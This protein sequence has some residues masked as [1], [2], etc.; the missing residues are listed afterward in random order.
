MPM[1]PSKKKKT[2]TDYQSELHAIS[3]LPL[4]VLDERLQKMRGK[5]VTVQ[6]Q[7]I[8]PDR[9]AFEIQHR[10]DRRINAQVYGTLQRWQGTYSRLDADSQVHVFGQW[11]NYALMIGQLIVFTVLSLGFWAFMFIWSATFPWGFALPV[12]I[13]IAIA[14]MYKL[15]QVD[16]FREEHYCALKDVDYLMQEVADT[17]TDNMPD[18][19]PML[20]FDGSDDALALLLSRHPIQGHV[21][22]DGELT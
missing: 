5:R 13:L 14:M 6:I 11:L 7:R 15:P 9:L 22:N 4:D 8:D 17:L 18:A 1:M 16:L 19:Q 10:R 20:E 12:S 2:F 3:P 21:G